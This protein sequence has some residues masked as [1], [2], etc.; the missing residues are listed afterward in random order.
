MSARPRLGAAFGVNELEA[1]IDWL[2]EH[3]RDLE[4]QSFI[5]ADTLNGDWR[6]L[7]SKATALLAAHKG[8]VGIHGPF[9]GFS[10]AT[11]D[12]DVRAVIKRRLDQGLDV[13]EALGATHMVIHSPVTTW[14]QENLLNSENGEAQQG[15]AFSAAMEEAVRRAEALN[16]TMVLEN[17]EDRDPYARLRLVKRFDS[18]ALK[19]SIDTGHAHYAH[20]MQ[21]AP[22]VDRY[23]RAAGNMLAHVHLQDS[24]GFADRH[25]PLGRGTVP[26]HGIFEELAK[27][28]S[29]PRLIIELRD[30][31]KVQASAAAM[32]TAGYAC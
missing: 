32:E 18:P 31:S 29:N 1:N 11:P 9:W 15:A 2:V 30:K 23:V 14:D 27:L 12:P 25:W 10:L 17:I 7:A 8:R 28:T 4:L 16:V 22:T 19:L 20:A 26:W 21:N 5:S 3:H 6:P 13:C 24:D